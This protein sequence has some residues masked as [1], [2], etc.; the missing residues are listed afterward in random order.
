LKKFYLIT[1]YYN[2]AHMKKIFT[3]I[4]YFI[5]VHQLTAQDNWYRSKDNAYYWKNR[6]PFEGY[7]QQDVHYSIKAKL[8]DKDDIVDAS[9]EIDFIITIQTILC[10]LCI[11]I[12]TKMLLLKVHI[13]EQLNLANNFKQKFGKY[14][15]EGKG[16]EVESVKVNGANA[17]LSLDNTIMKVMLPTPL[18]PNSSVASSCNKNLEPILMQMAHNADARKCSRAIGV[19]NNTMVCIG[20]RV[21]VCMIGS[22]VGK[23][24]QH[25]GRREF[26]EILV[27]YDVELQFA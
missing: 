10:T 9:E 5:F 6:K 22:L 25:L 24:N 15:A 4:I 11:F 17:T 27:S 14:E 1:A 2:I 8:T 12:C 3:L 19:T 13:L 21:F 26:M 23:P 20:I 18:M 7:W 16:T